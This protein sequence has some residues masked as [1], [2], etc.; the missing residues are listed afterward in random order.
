M[1][2]QVIKSYVIHLPAFQVVVCCSCESC[3]PPKDPLD[4]FKRNHSSAKSHFVPM[5]VHRKI[6]AYM[7]TLNLCDPHDVIRP[8]QVIPELKVIKN[9]FVCNFPGCGSCGISELS[10][11]THYYTHQNSVPKDFKGWEETSY[12]T[13]FD[14]I[15]KK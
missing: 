1:T 10:M 7:A 14:G 12:Q 3:I 13:F 2:D 11:R 9:G 6:M 5:A 4:H 8:D 15:H